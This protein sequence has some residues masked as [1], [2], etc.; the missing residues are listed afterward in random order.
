MGRGAV[1]GGCGLPGRGFCRG[2]VFDFFGDLVSMMR[3]TSVAAALFLCDSR[4]MSLASLNAR[5]CALAISASY[6][7]K[8]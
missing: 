1:G 7:E 4:M 3:G 6:S 2:L 8:P 5:N